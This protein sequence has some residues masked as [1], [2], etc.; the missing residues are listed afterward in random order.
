MPINLHCCWFSINKTNRWPPHYQEGFWY[1]ESNKPLVM[2]SLLGYDGSLND[3]CIGFWTITKNSTPR[4]SLKHW[5]I[6]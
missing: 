1:R 2:I 6:L 5:G 3:H 4:L